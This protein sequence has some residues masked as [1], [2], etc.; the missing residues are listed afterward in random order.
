MLRLK[1]KGQLLLPIL[2]IVIIGVVAVQFF[3]YSKSSDILENQ[4]KTT[5]VLETDAAARALENWVETMSGNLHN[6]SRNELFLRA[7]EDG[8]LSVSEATSFAEDALKDF[9]WYEGV[10]LVG[11]DGKVIAASPESYATLDVSDRSYFM[12]AMKGTQG[13]S[14]P[15]TSRATGNPIFV[16]SSPIVDKTGDVRGAIFIVVD[17]NSLN[18]LIL[19]PIKIGENGYA[20]AINPEG[21][22]IAHPNQE[23][24]MSL[25]ISETEYGKEMISRRTGTYKYY[26]DQQNQ[27][28]LMAF[29][30]VESADWL[31]AITAPLGE[32][33]APLVKTR[34]AAILGSILT[35]IAAALVILFIVGR[36]TGT[37]KS[38]VGI[39]DEIAKGDLTKKIGYENRHDEIGQ[40]AG[41]IREMNIRLRE[42]I[43][44][45]TNSVAD[46]STGSQEISV[47]AQQ[48]S[49][50]A[51]EQA[52]G[53]EEV[54]ASMEQMSSNIQQNND[55][56]QQTE[57]IAQKVVIDATLSGDSVDK[58]VIAMKEIANKIS[59]IEEIARQTNLL[60]LNAA[61]EAARA[62]DHGKGFAVVASEVRKLAE[63]SGVAAGEISDL[64]RN[65]VQIAETAGNLLTELVPNIQKTA[66]LVQE[67]SAASNEQRIGVEQINSSIIQLDKVIQQNSASSE[68]LAATSEELSSQSVTLLDLTRYFNTGTETRKAEQLIKN[69]ES[70][71]KVNKKKSISTGITIPESTFANDEDFSDF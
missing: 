30:E 5:I 16:V 34:N 44:N 8:S 56:A 33:M 41:S 1:L 46:V 45:I 53:A 24:I 14:R 9:P 25:D 66:E 15:L 54:S 55:N 62:G 61:I 27:W 59:I 18:D 67:I 51:T 4:I 71:K 13:R 20:F 38:F 64:S 47:S 10:A 52:A 28:K 58:T 49:Q 2:S 36:I 63:R 22:I 60:A 35:I 11:P 68:E 3:T 29:A 39:F 57:K 50:G 23:Y 12:D 26:F 43:G 40:L 6:W 32:I 31:I 21:L 17:I 48:I 19:A 7:I 69:T 70:I 65:S 37:F 42:I